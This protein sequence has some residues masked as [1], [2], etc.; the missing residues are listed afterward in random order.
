MRI[1]AIL[2]V[3]FLLLGNHAFAQETWTLPMCIEHAL[4][5]NLQ[6]Q[7]ASL[8]KKAAR[9]NM[10]QSLATTLPSINGFAT[11]TYNF[12]QTIDPFTNQF[13]SQQVRSNSLGINGQW[14]LFSG[15]QNVNTVQQ[16]RLNYQA[17]TYDFEKVRNDIALAVTQAYMQAIFADEQLRNVDAQQQLTKEQRNRIE[18]LYQAGNVAKSVL[19]DMEAQLAQEELQVINSQNQVAI[20]YLNLKQL[21]EIDADKNIVLQGPEADDPENIISPQQAK[22]IY[23]TSLTV[24]PQIKSAEFRYASA[25]KRLAAA[26][27]G[28]S[29]R[30]SI[31]ANYGSGYSGLQK[32]VTGVNIT[33]LDTIGFTG[34]GDFVY[35]PAYAFETQTKSFNDQLRDNINR[36][37]GFTLSI[38]LF[39]GWMVRN[40][41]SQAKIGMLNSQLE[42]EQSK[43]QVQKEVQ[44]AHADALAAAQR[45]KASKKSYLAF[46]E[47]YAYAQSRFTEGM[48]NSIEFT[49]AKNKFIRSES[50]M[51]QAKYD[52]LFKLKI[53]DFYMGKPITF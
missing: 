27:G 21:M 49:D 22:N 26:R 32:E 16:N 6:I 1:P 13:A 10:E 8:S 20:S 3:M 44:T 14:M 19:L 48:L 47:S 30:L 42:L 4:K 23:E 33:G 43:R 31:S 2:P 50:E 45:Y 39:N 38:P 53:L 9:S 12:G 40:N 7:Q 15:W 11:N 36:S 52:L 41:I 51:L 37:V 24:L 5:N 18:K 34:M 28:V 46:K 25:G 17:A 29:P 35:R